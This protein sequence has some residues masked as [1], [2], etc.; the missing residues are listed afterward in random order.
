[1]LYNLVFGTT[2]LHELLFG[3]LATDNLTALGADYV[4][5]MF[6]RVVS[7]FKICI[8]SS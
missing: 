8:S 4:V 5:L 6:K 3:H 2:I 1:M 7:I